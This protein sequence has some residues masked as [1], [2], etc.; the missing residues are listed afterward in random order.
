MPPLMQQ[1]RAYLSQFTLGQRIALGI[2]V[3]G[4][5][6]ALISLSLWANRPEFALLYNNLAPEDASEMVDQLRDDNVPYRLSNGGSAIHVPTENVSDY[7]LSFAA[8]GLASGSVVGF[9]LFDEQRM[10]MTTFMQRVN[11]QRALEGE[12]V[13]TL[14]Q[15]DEVRM[16]R[17]HLV[18]PEKKFFDEMATATAAVTLHLQ[19]GTYL[20]RRQIQGITAMIANSVPDLKQENVS[21][22]DASGKLL[23]DSI[24][25]RDGAG[26]GSKNWEVRQ[27]VER[28]LQNKAQIILDNLLGIGRSR[29]SVAAILNFEQL[30]RVSETFDTED[31]AIRSEETSTENFMGSD[32]SNR[33]LQQ[34]V[35]NYE[36]NK[37]IETFVASTGDITRLTVSVLVDG[38]YNLG[39]NADGDEINVYEPRSQT[40]LVAI[41]ALIASA[42]GIDRNR[43]DE[44]VVENLQFDRVEELAQLASIRSIERSQYWQNL[45]TNAGIAIA[46]I[47]AAFFLMRTLKS[48]TAMTMTVFAPPK[49]EGAAVGVAGVGE[50]AGAT[51]ALEAK[52]VR[53]VATDSFLMKL[54]PEARAKLEAMDAMTHDVTQFTEDNPEGAAQ[55]LR[56]WTS[57]SQG[58]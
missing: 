24:H 4:V 11:Y 52:G 57:E 5:L 48:S 10:G 6:S 40:D 47:L 32:T 12:L 35:T 50:I 31:S 30:E 9:E 1:I 8:E 3:I 27:A 36:L 49:P 28:E 33:S 17:V 2:I 29:V 13:K 42:I 25:D 43:G 53:E 7:R 20:G 56:I 22:L 21:V 14:N 54:S 58:Q 45:G 16:S 55:L 26:F 34:T 15:L 18:I 51:G 44:I 19:P 46:I 39:T 38:K 41:E 37:T 23:T